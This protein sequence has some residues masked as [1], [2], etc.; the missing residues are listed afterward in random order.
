MKKHL[1]WE[2]NTHPLSSDDIVL[3]GT[4]LYNKASYHVSPLPGRWWHL[5][6]IPFFIN[7]SAFYCLGQAWDS[8][9]A[10][11]LFVKWISKMNKW[12]IVSI[13]SAL[14]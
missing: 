3:R 6:G 2:V 1:L 14:F 13:A 8:V 12:M 5:H 10:Q 4:I 9:D 11:R 7:L